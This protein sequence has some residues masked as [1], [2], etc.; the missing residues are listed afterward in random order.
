MRYNTCLSH[1]TG[2]IKSP[3]C[4]PSSTMRSSAGVAEPLLYLFVPV[5]SPTQLLSFHSSLLGPYF[6]YA[7]CLVHDQHLCLDVV[8][9]K[10]IPHSLPAEG[11]RSP[12][13]MRAPASHLLH[14]R[15]R[16]SECILDL[17][18]S[19]THKCEDGLP[20]SKRPSHENERSI[21]P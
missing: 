7:V 11:L 17:T 13:Q 1:Q 16:T 19:R 5:L 9:Q 15:I 21:V 14:R 18:M 4:S 20:T 3:Q 12:H 2:S 10:N 6:V 8:S